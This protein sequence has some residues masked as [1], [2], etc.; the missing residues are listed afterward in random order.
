MATGLSIIILA[1]DDCRA[2]SGEGLSI[3]SEIHIE[4]IIK[5]KN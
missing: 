3:A 1:L 2:I 4:N 5:F